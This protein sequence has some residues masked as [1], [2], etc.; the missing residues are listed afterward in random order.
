MPAPRRALGRRG[1]AARRRHP[2]GAWRPTP[3]RR[4]RSALHGPWRGL[5]GALPGVRQSTWGVPPRSP[6]FFSCQTGRRGTHATAWGPQARG[7]WGCHPLPGSRQQAAGGTPCREAAQRTRQLG[8]MVAPLGGAIDSRCTTRARVELHAQAV[9]AFLG[10]RGFAL[11][12]AL[13]DPGL[14][15]LADGLVRLD[16]CLGLPLGLDL[17]LTGF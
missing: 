1:F 11:G 9:V 15:P 10:L 12:A 3:C 7:I 5:E 6:A 8:A 17:R 2:R 13:G 16:Q 4:L 14:Y